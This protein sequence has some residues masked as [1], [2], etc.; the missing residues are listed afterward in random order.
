MTPQEN[1]SSM[2]GRKRSPLSAEKKDDKQVSVGVREMLNFHSSG[3]ST[4]L[5]FLNKYFG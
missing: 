4:A 5:A 2:Q 1:Q 3:I